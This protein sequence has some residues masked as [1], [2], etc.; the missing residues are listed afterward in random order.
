MINCEVW[1]ILEIQTGHYNKHLIANDIKRSRFVPLTRNA[2]EI[3]AVALY[4]ENQ[5]E[6]N[7][8][9]LFYGNYFDQK[10]PLLLYSQ[11]KFA[12]NDE[13]QRFPML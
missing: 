5:I 3:S 6:L 10:L 8:S 1:L 13:M 9:V 4:K 11:G 7:G 12:S 2:E